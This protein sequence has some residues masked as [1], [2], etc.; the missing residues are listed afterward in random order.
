MGIAHM[1][2]TFLPL[3]RRHKILKDS[4]SK[5]RKF[6]FIERVMMKHHNHSN[7]IKVIKGKDTIHQNNVDDNSSNDSSKSSK[8]KTAVGS[9]NKWFKMYTALIEFKEKH[10]HCLVPNRYTE[11]PQLGSWVST[12]R[13]QYKLMKLKQ[14]PP[15]T[16]GRVKLLEAVGFVWATRDPRHVPWETRFEQLKEYQK[17]NGH[18]L[19]PI[20]HKDNPQLSNWVSTQ[21]QEY[22]LLLNGRKSRITNERIQKL[23][24]IG[25]V[26]E[27]HRGGKK[28]KKPRKIGSRNFNGTIPESHQDITPD[29]L[30]KEQYRRPEYSS[31]KSKTH[32]PTHH[33]HPPRNMYVPQLHSPRLSPEVTHSNDNFYDK[34]YPNNHKTIYNGISFK[35]GSP[36]FQL[37]LSTR[38]QGSP[39]SEQNNYRHQFQDY[40]NQ[41][42][43]KI[44]MGRTPDPATSSQV[45]VP[46]NYHTPKT[47]FTMTTPD[48]F[49]LEKIWKEQYRH[50]VQFKA[51]HGHCNVPL[52][53][54][55]DPYLRHWVFIQQE[56]FQLW[57]EGKQST[58]TFP[59]YEALNKIGFE[60]KSTPESSQEPNLIFST[61][62]EKTHVNQKEFYQEKNT[63]EVTPSPFVKQI[64][65]SRNV[66]SASSDAD[67]NRFQG[68]NK[69]SMQA[70][71]ALFSLS[72][73]TPSSYGSNEDVSDVKKVKKQRFF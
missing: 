67:A 45:H 23:N 6:D 35:M 21:R 46:K 32:K 61:P 53:Y 56:Q 47:H 31:L 42:T 71:I 9:S 52:N 64:E 11:N 49:T 12:Q 58:M 72:N 70:A 60:W 1:G 15:M 55:L 5:K 57:K 66:S 26:W 41:S 43:P 48:S 39:L 44:N 59:R 7:E 36:F 65:K 63:Q 27:A 18:C 50:L 19:I 24:E 54:N 25:F 62:Q 20:G 38:I 4:I 28:V 3:D 40:N 16:P 2:N 10:G 17:T 22:K 30:L 8:T 33:L 37:N 73:A 29:S 34:Y 68:I 69:N 13:R 51:I 14:L